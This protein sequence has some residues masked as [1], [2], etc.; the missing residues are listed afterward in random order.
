MILRLPD[1]GSLDKLQARIKAKS[2]VRSN[3]LVGSHAQGAPVGTVKNDFK[4]VTRSEL[5]DEFSLQVRLMKLPA[6]RIQ[7]QPFTHRK[8]R[9]DFA[10][11]DRKIA[12]LVQGNVHRIKDKFYRDCELFCLL[13]MAG[14]KYLPVSRNE[15]KSTE[16]AQ[17]AKELLSA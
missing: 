1:Q 4:S 3:V 12:V 17:W 5:E 7:Y 13:T 6:P 15:I 14:W 9:L 11:P 8:H 10:W 16:A 2:G